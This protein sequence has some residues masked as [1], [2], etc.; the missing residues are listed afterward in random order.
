M[1]FLDAVRCIV[2]DT[3]EVHI[4]DIWFANVNSPSAYRSLEGL[5][6]PVL[7]VSGR[8]N[9]GKTAFWKCWLERWTGW[10]SGLR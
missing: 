2:V 10:E 4:P 1:K 7:A 8:K 5:R 9:T 6:T 3:S